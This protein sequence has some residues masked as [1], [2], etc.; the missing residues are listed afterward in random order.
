MLKPDDR[1]AVLMHDGLKGAKGKTGISILRY[2][3]NPVVAVIDESA[4][5][6]SVLALTGLD[7]DIPIVADVDAA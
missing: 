2:S 5:G 3:Q 7:R 1:I 4:V 6:D